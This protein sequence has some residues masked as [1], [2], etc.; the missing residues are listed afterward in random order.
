MRVDGKPSGVDVQNFVAALR[1]GTPLNT[2]T[3]APAADVVLPERNSDV[4]VD[5]RLAGPLSGYTWPINGKLYD[6]PNDGI[7]LTR[8][9]RVR[10]RLISDSMMFHPIHLHGHTFQVVG[11]PRKDTVL[12]P[13]RQTVEVDFDTDNP[14]RWIVHC[15]NDYHLGAGMA[16]FVEYTG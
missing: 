12:V 11:G 16:T 4:T 8:G 14:G 7:P 3:L 5:L 15:H 10:L 13:P 2:A 9:M 1:T 6:P